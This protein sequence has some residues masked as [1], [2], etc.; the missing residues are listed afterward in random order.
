MT[1]LSFNILCRI[2]VPLYKDMK[3]QFI[4]VGILVNIYHCHRIKESKSNLYNDILGQVCKKIRTFMPVMYGKLY[5]KGV[6]FSSC[7]P[8][9]C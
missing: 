3:Q 6:W 2:Y 5:G 8:C 1:L 7:M 9:S 4:Y